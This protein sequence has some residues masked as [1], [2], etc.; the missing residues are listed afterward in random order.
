MKVAVIPARG[1]SKR[2]PR[3][4]IREFCGKP[5]LAYA[6]IAAQQSG[7]FD[8]IVVSTDDAE[9]AEVARQWGAETPFTRPP[10]LADDYAGTVPVIA[11]AIHTCQ[12]QGWDINYVC[13]IYPA[14]PLIQVADIQTALTLLEESRASY[15]FPVAE[16]PAAVQRAL[17]RS[18]HGYLKPFYPEYE[19]ERTQDLETA[20]YDAGQF[21]WGTAYAWL[22]NS[23]LHSTGVGLVVPNWRMVDIDTLDDWRRAELIYKATSN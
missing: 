13:C 19:A 4:N 2:I 5:M 11:H 21:Y 16:F 14:V 22:N 3:K 12:E 9:I 8:R 10:E 23:G 17:K 18:S 1:G 6:V 20:Y 15:V 7:L